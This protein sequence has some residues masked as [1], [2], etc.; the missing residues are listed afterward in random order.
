MLGNLSCFFSFKINFF[1]NVLS[2][3]LSNGLDPDQNRHSLGPDL[4][5][6]ICKGELMTKV[7]TNKEKK[8]HHIFYGVESWS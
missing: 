3:T 7:A 2:G 8:W 5:P 6:T 1:K 4:S